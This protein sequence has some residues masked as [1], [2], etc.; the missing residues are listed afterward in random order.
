M[1]IAK[2]FQRMGGTSVAE[3][4]S[5]LHTQ[6]SYAFYAGAVT[7]GQYRP[8]EPA[9]LKKVLFDAEA[10]LKPAY[11]IELV[12][13]AFDSVVDDAYS[14][15]I[16]AE[17]GRVLFRKNLVSSLAFSY[18]VY[19]DTMGKHLPMDS[20]SGNS[21][22]PN[23][24]GSPSSP[25]WL[26]ESVP[27][28]LITLQSGPIQN[29]DPWLS[30]Q[31]ITTNGNNA[32]AYMDISA[33]N[34]YQESRGDMRAIVNAERTFDYVYD[35]LQAPM[36]DSVQ[37]QAAIVQLFY[38][39]N[40]LHDWFYDV[41]FDEASGNAQLD[42]YGRGGQAGDPLLAEA[43][44]YSMRDNA[45]ITV[46]AD[47]SSPRMEM[48]LWSGVADVR[49]IVK[50]P[51]TLGTLVAGRAVFGPRTFQLLGNLVRMDDGLEP[52]R[53]GCSTVINPAPLV[54]KIVLI[55]RGVCFFIDKVRHAQAA[56]A[57]G[58]LIVND[59]DETLPITMNGDAV[60]ISIPSL[61]ILKSAGQLLDA[62]LATGPVQL[63]LVRNS[64][65]D[66]S[67]AMDSLIVAHE[68]GHLISNRL[69]GNASGLYNGQGESLGEG[70]S[71]FH[72]LLVAV[73]K[74][75]AQALNNDKFQGAYAIGSYVS[76]LSNEGDP[77]YFGLRR[78]PYSSDF[79]KNALT[80]KHIENDVA[81]PD[82]HPRHHTDS[83][84]AEP[85]A[86]GEVWTTMLW[87]VYAALLRDS[88]RLN[89]AQAQKR[90]MGYLVAAYKMTPLD[91]TFTEARDA[92]LAVA[93]ASDPKDYLLMAE[94]FARRGLGFTAR[95]PD[96]YS[97]DNFGVRESFAVNNSWYV[98]NAILDPS[99]VSCDQDSVLDVGE[100]ARLTLTLRNDAPVTLPAS[101]ATLSSTNAVRF[102][103]AGLVTL[104]GVKPGATVQVSTELTLDR[105]NHG[106][107]L[108]V[109]MLPNDRWAGSE[110]TV[111]TVQVNM[112]L[113]A[114]FT[115][116]SVD[117]PLSDWTMGNGLESG[118]VA[119][120]IRSLDGGGQGYWGTDPDHPSDFWLESPPIRLADSGASSFWFDHSYAFEEDADGAWDGGVLELRVGSD[121]AWQD[122]G[123][124]MRS[125]YNGTILASNAVLG[126]R[127]AFVGSSPGYPAFITE[128]VDLGDAFHGQE[129][130]IRF[131]IGSDQYIGHDGWIVRNIY[132]A[133]IAN[134]PFTSVVNNAVSCGVSPPGDVAG[135]HAVDGV[136]RGLAAGDTLRM[137]AYAPSIGHQ[138]SVDLLGHGGDLGFS[139]RGLLP[140]ADYQLF[141]SAD[142][143]QDGY[144]GGVSG[145]APMNVVAEF[146][147]AVLDLSQNGLAGINLQ[148][149]LEHTLS[150]TLNGAR[151]G[152]ELDVTVWSENTSSL[153]WQKVLVQES[154]TQIELP[155][156]PEA[157]DYLLSI[158][159]HGND[160]M[161]G[162]Y[163][164]ENR[165]VGP[166]LQARRFNIAADMAI[167]LKMVV[168]RRITGHVG[169]GEGVSAWVSAWSEQRWS[170]AVVA[171][172]D[173]GDYTLNGLAAAA[174]YRICVTAP[175]LAGG[176]Y[177]GNMTVPYRLAIPVDVTLDDKMGIDLTLEEGYRI[178]GQVTGLAE[179]DNSAWVEAWSTAT[180]HWAT[181]QVGNDGSFILAGLPSA[182]DY[183]VTLVAPGYP[184]TAAQ[185]VEVGGNT[186]SVLADGTTATLVYFNSNSISNNGNS[187]SDSL[188]GGGIAGSIRGLQR[189]D[190]VTLSLRSLATGE[191]RDVTLMAKDAEPLAYSLDGLAEAQD[192]EIS[193]QTPQGLFYR[194]ANNGLVRH[195]QDRLNV[196][197][198]A[199]TTVS[200]IDFVLGAEV[201]YSLFGSIS[202]LQTADENLLLTV[203]AW[204]EAG[205]FGSTR[206]VGNGDW[207]ITGLGRGDYRILVQS[208]GYV[209][210]F[211][212]GF[213][214]GSPV[215]RAALKDAETFSVQADVHGLD[216][217]LLAGHAITGMVV[218]ASN[219]VVA[220][221]RVS[222]WDSF[223]DVGGGAMT[224]ADGRFKIA[225]MADGSYQLQINSDHGDYQ[226][227]LNSLTDDRDLGSITLLKQT[228]AVAG[229]VT[230][231]GAAQALI[232]VYLADGTYVTAT[233]T[234]GNGYYYVDNLPTGKRYRLDCDSNNDFSVMEVTAMVDVNGLVMVNMDLPGTVQK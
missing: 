7:Q 111:L 152:D 33:P 103:N 230:G 232:L 139:L 229:T 107:M 19:A 73:R 164:G 42:N 18:R 62:A 112:D 130:S 96:R 97:T 144:W 175:L 44:D 213:N 206:R 9:R 133:G 186:S 82:S 168:G 4:W 160:L 194:G 110:Q 153:A 223:Q 17:D 203:T 11:Y 86:A 155:G 70:W 8:R 207:S 75:D 51:A 159:S 84:N 3:A 67:G 128:M 35:P 150:V 192:Y 90:M 181:V 2:A 214:S 132:F 198:V 219:S 81:L 210:Q 68:W 28:S 66:L 141:V 120:E 202:G 56:G 172:D 225:G 136:L 74:E 14:H 99:V 212:T 122:L 124:F 114:A 115:Q 121:A 5:L 46:F 29:A 123:A 117:K 63:T 177:A 102:T 189:R 26:P 10:G 228:G 215:W 182:N 224:L 15:V 88:E 87:E 149:A 49:V 54:G 1:A 154:V 137:T 59:K 58:V 55:D 45:R 146:R 220:D 57:I 162:F 79:D 24:L 25:A 190:V 89:F 76:S 60:D 176:C 119:W 23:P 188:R 193:L 140:A 30:A 39:V 106:E 197:I 211:F 16:S 200:G 165:G 37:N 98:V 92:L 205:D 21:G 147:G 118:N 6:G 143:Y 156:L 61:F 217:Q 38:T 94:A 80:F 184:A 72:S 131:R 180:G 195:W 125:G 178:V 83:E 166:F 163:T 116:D 170:G 129:I 148:L 47:G 85:H 13:G 31:A 126:D 138:A 204:S 105:A 50:Q 77:Y 104:P 234:D 108:E 231:V 216:L 218:D 222:V 52:I 43:Q 158:T 173:A 48:F 201:S 36:A 183:Q 113:K 32:D 142:K 64:A 157:D 27:Q 167:T 40:F 22:T 69:I 151:R 227:R 185:M 78:V 135:T 12:A 71:D 53:D 171:L 93:M 127:P 145:E 65:R 179:G 169:R 174:D 41:G 100:T 221:V 208:A 191:N 226:T 187:D 134:L 109:T 101:S 196:A 161:S 199:G 209:E 233:V 34:G 20:P 91:P 95:S